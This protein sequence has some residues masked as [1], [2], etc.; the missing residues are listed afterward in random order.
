LRAHAIGAG[1]LIEGD[2]DGDKKAD[3]AIE[4]TNPGHTIVWSNTSGDD[5]DF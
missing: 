3:F 2:L 5:F 1:Y 4:I